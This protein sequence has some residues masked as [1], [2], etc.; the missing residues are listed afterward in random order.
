MVRKLAASDSVNLANL[1]QQIAYQARQ[2]WLR[3]QREHRETRTNLARA[4][5]E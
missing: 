3:H 5:I 4:V 1:G 2:L